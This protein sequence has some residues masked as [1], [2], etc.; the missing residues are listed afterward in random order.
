[1][2]KH[3]KYRNDTYTCGKHTHTHIDFPAGTDVYPLVR[4]INAVDGNMKERHIHASSNVW[5]LERH[6]DELTTLQ[7][8]IWKP[9]SPKLYRKHFI[10]VLR[11]C[12]DDAHMMGVPQFQGVWLIKDVRHFSRWR[13]RLRTSLAVSTGDRESNKGSKSYL[14]N[15][16]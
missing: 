16:D 6:S 9:R 7:Q 12:T 8:L 5:K 10:T 15:Q 2:P 4:P 11:R 13:R 1:M 14:P 3:E